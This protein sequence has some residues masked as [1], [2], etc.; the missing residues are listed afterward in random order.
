MASKV[1]YSE[2]NYHPYASDNPTILNYSVGKRLSNS[3][4]YWATRSSEKDYHF[5]GYEPTTG[6]AY[7]HYNYLTSWP[8]RCIEDPFNGQI[9]CNERNFIGPNYKNPFYVGENFVDP[10]EPAIGSPEER[11]LYTPNI[12]INQALPVNCPTIEKNLNDVFKSQEENNSRN[13]IEDHAIKQPPHEISNINSNNDPV[14]R[15]PGH[16]ATK[17][18]PRNSNDQQKAA[19]VD[20]SFE[21]RKITGNENYQGTNIHKKSTI[22]GFLTNLCNYDSK[23]QN[24][25]LFTGLLILGFIWF[26]IGRMSTV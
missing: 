4:P 23:N 2:N 19:V 11:N 1:L 7:P 12:P 26:L 10:D 14:Y 20:L 24:L 9:I 16:V 25:Y 8:K 6:Y 15:M 3:G 21:E 17:R 22:T 18:T 13:S 5:D